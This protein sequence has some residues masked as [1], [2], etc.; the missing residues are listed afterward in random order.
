MFVVCMF[1]GGEL[2]FMILIKGKSSG[3]SG[4]GLFF[5]IFIILMWFYLFLVLVFIVVF[6]EC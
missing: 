4:I 1:L 2:Y 3:F 6:F 5:F